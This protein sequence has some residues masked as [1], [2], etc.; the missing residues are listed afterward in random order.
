MMT[1]S[2]IRRLFARPVT[3]TI[4][5]APHRAGPALEALEDRCVPSTFVV[6]NPTDTPVAGETDLR[7]AITLAN[8]NPGADTITF[9]STVFSTPQTITL[10]GG[11]LT[12][13]DPATTTITGPAAPQPPQ[14]VAAAR[15]VRK[16]G[17]A[18]QGH[19]HSPIRSRRV[20]LRREYWPVLTTPC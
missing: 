5:K 20:P 4:R 8:L 13:T 6:D 12:L 15:W 10:T 3:G 19:E 7:Q 16:S 14:G 9:D 17:P 11:Q 2:W 1:R 18:S